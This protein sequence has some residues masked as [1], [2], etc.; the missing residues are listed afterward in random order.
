MDR[1]KS[2]IARAISE[3]DEGKKVRPG[4]GVPVRITLS[5]EN[6]RPVADG[7]SVFYSSGGQGTL[8]TDKIVRA[9]DRGLEGMTFNGVSSDCLE[10]VVVTVSR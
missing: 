8:D 9:A 6:G 5:I 1:M 10:P 2:R 3:C 4:V 7:A